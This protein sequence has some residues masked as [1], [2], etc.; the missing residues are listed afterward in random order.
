MQ[1]HFDEA[2]LKILKTDLPIIHFLL[3]NLVFMLD[4]Y[5]HVVHNGTENISL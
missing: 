3:N 5:S 4:I 2:I 1:F